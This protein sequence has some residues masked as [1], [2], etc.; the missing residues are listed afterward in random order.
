M[1]ASATYFDTITS[2]SAYNKQ[3]Q[4]ELKDKSFTLSVFDLKSSASKWGRRQLLA[5]QVVVSP[6][7]RDLLPAYN[8]QHIAPDDQ[9]SDEA[10][11]QI[12]KFLQGPDPNFL[13]QIEHNLV[14]R[15]GALGGIWAP[16]ADINK[17]RTGVTF[18]EVL[19]GDS[20]TSE[21]GQGTPQSKRVRRNPSHENFVNSGSITIA[22][23]SPGN[24]FPGSSP[25]SS[26]GWTE[27]GPIQDLHLEGV[28]ALL[29]SRMLLHIL[30]YTQIPGSKQTVA[31]RYN[32]QRMSL[33]IPGLDSPIVAIDDG[34]LCLQVEQ[35]DGHFT[36]PSTM[37]A[38]LEAKRCLTISNGRPVI[39]DDCLAQMACEAILARAT[40]PLAEFETPSVTIINA[41][42]H[43]ACFLQFDVED[44]YIEALKRGELPSQPLRVTTTQWFDLN[45][46]RG[47]SAVLKNV[48][49]L[50]QLAKQRGS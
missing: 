24:K 22:S 45:E 47:R 49:G 41:T 50:V 5:C 10:K 20:P 30:W 43:Y 19:V 9:R 39:S 38:L 40:D 14:H 35:R 3:V 34:G 1:S 17:R 16:L 29:I 32:N 12:D 27:Q 8:G 26:I 2:K 11:S 25:N 6:T 48:C 31:F 42:Q 37:V 13:Y 4:S 44:A 15:Y 21:Q 18:P 46:R 36:T 28:T 33:R 7:S 23:S